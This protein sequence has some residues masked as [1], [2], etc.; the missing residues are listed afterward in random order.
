MRKAAV[1]DVAWGASRSRSC[2]PRR[3][4]A[5]VRR[6]RSTAHRPA[7]CGCP[8]RRGR[9]SARQRRVAGRTARPRRWLR[10]RVPSAAS[11]G[12]RPPS[13]SASVAF[14][15]RAPA[16]RVVRAAARSSSAS[17][18]RS[19]CMASAC[20][21]AEHPRGGTGAGLAAHHGDTPGD[22]RC[23]HAGRLS[24]WSEPVR[25]KAYSPAGASWRAA[26]WHARASMAWRAA[27]RARIV[28]G[29][30]RDLGLGPVAAG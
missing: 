13:T 6:S 29:R 5:T 9:Q 21:Q 30:R 19:P 10:A 11:N 26:H 15:R 7:P 23:Q 8:A 17:S 14:R 20:G 28:E 24:A 25:F 3:P 18:T 12:T 1:I 16:S 27:A 4:W 22:A 2:A